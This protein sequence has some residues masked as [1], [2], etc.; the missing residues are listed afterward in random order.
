[1][2]KKIFSEEGLSAFFK[3]IIPSLILTLVPVIQFTSYEFLKLNLSYS[4]GKISN[5]NL[6]MISFFSKFISILLNY[7]LMTLK[8]LYQSNSTFSNKE[9]IEIIKRVLLKEGLLGFYK[10]I[11]SKVLGSV[12]NNMILMLTYERLQ[13]IVRLLLSRL[14]LGKSSSKIIV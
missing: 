7:P 4:D 13:N 6:V 2:I 3:G 10:G 8:T 5:K 14:L 1:M 12:L 9:I 11:G